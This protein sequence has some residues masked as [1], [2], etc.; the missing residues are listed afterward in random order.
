MTESERESRN[1]LKIVGEVMWTLER[2]GKGANRTR[3]EGCLS[4]KGTR[5]DVRRP[6][7]D[8]HV[9]LIRVAQQSRDLNTHRIHIQM[10]DPL[11]TT[12]RRRVS[13]DVT[14]LKCVRCSKHE[15]AVVV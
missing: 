5:R 15:R 10:N 1:E 4:T 8:G 12:S 9:I 3:P 7:S 14:R 2:R 6:T 13:C 11:R